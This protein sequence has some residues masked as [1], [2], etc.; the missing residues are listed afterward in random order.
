MKRK[1]LI[2]SALIGITA[3][4]KGDLYYV[5]DQN[6]ESLPIKWSVG[7]SLVYDDNVLAGRG[8]TNVPKE[9]SFAINPYV[10]VSW[11][12]VTPQ[13]TVDVYARLGMVYYFDAPSGVDDVNSQSRL[14]VNLTHRFSERLRWVSRNFVAYELE[15]DYSRGYANSRIADEYFYWQTQN[16]LGFRWTDRFAT[17]TGF[18]LS[19]VDYGGSRDN[20]R[21]TWGL[22]NQFRYQLTEQ[23]VST[24]E[25]RYRDTDA[26]G[27]GRDSKDHYVLLGVE[28]RFNPNT[29]GILRVGYQHRDVSG[30]SNR[31]RPS[32]E[33]A[34]DSQVNDQFRV[35]AFTR[36]SM[37]SYDTVRTVNNFASIVD[38]DERQT[39]RIGVSG[40]YLISPKLSIN[41]GVDY[42]YT[43][44]K[45]GFDVLAQAPTAG[46]FDDDIVNLHIG[47]SYQF[48]DNVF[49]TLSYNYS[50]SSS[51][52]DGRDYTRNRV[53]VGVRA[54]F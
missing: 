15:P 23:T 5:G 49:G 53:A 41:G 28:H 27:V 8:N 48:V 22:S 33:F 4:A 52:L 47:L 50:N 38:F 11:V 51:D 18:M 10:G 45:G 29:V 43:D 14:G 7:G 37:E 2:F 34:L 32:L 44:Y 30:G 3:V 54:E 35:R 12:N 19:G 6:L 46:S 9:D 25:Y 40:E 31:D 16:S 21:F 13:T 26:S 39:L 1:I 36:Y 42:I 17:Y 20:D 24:L